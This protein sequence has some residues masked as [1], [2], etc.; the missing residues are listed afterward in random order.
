[1]RGATGPAGPTGAAAKGAFLPF[2]SGNP[3]SLTTIAGGLAGIPAFIG[4]GSSAQGFT[5]LKSTIDLTNANGS[6]ACFAFDIPRTIAISAFS[7]SF[8]TTT[9]LSLTGSTVTINAQVYKAEG[10]SNVFSPIE[11]TL[12]SLTPSLSGVVS[13]GTVLKGAS[14]NTTVLVNQGSRLMVVLSATASG[15]SP[16]NTITGYVSAGIILF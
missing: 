12:V 5:A 4:F 7:V 9:A 14:K 11:S 6:L 15:L 13:I 16:I 10:T 2:A 3:V 1:M 8:S